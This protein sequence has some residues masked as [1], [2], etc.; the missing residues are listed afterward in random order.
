MSIL[1]TRVSR[2][3]DPRLLTE[4]GTLHGR[5][6]RPCARGRRA[7]HVRAVD[8]GARAGR[9]GR[10]RRGAQRCPGVVDVV[11]GADVDLAPAARR[12]ATARWPGRSWPS[13][14]S[15]SSASRWP[16]CSPRPPSRAPTP[17]SWWS[18]TTSRCP[19]VVD[20]A[21]ALDGEV[22]AL[23]R[24]G[25]QPRRRVRRTRPA[26]RS[27][28]RR[29]ARSWSASASS[30]SGWPPARS[31]GGRPRRRWVDGRL[32]ALVLDA[33]RPRP[34]AT[35]WRRRYGLDEPTQVRVIAPDVGGG[36]GA[37]IGG[38][39]EDLAARLAGPA[40]RP[41]GALDRDPHREHDRPWSTAGPRSRT[42]T[43]GGR[44]DGTHRG[45]PPRHRP[46]RR[47]LPAIGARSCPCLTRMMAAGTYAI[48]AVDLAR[49]GSVVTNTTPVGSPTAAPAGPR[50]RPPSS[51]R[52]TCS[53][54]RSGLDPAEVRR[55]NLVPAFDEAAHHADR[56]H[57]R[58]RR[59][60][61]ALDRALAAAGLRRAAGRAGAGA[62]AAGDPARSASG[63]RCY[64]EV[65]ERAAR[66]Q[67]VRPGRGPPG[68]RRR[69]RRRVSSPRA[70]RPTARATPPRW[71]CSPP[72]QLGM[73]DRARRGRARRHRR[74]APA[75]RARSARA[76][77]SSAA[78]RCGRPPARWSSRARRA[79]RR[80]ARGRRRR[81]RA[82]PR[83]PAASTWSASPAVGRSWAEVARRRRRR[84]RRRSAA[85]ELRR[86]DFAATQPTFPFGAHVAVVE[87]DTE[88]G[89]VRLRAPRRL[90]RR[91][92]DRSTRCWPRAS[93]TAGWPRARPRRCTRRSR[94][95]ADGNPLTTNF[96]DYAI[97]SAAELPSFE[98]VDMET[99]TLGQP[100]RGQGHRR[101]GHDRLRRPAVQNAVCDAAR[102]PRRAPRRHALHARTGV[103]GD[104][105]AATSGRLTK[106]PSAGAQRRVPE[107]RAAG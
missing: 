105:R 14:G 29:A 10:R 54:P 40:L 7:R 63:C 58:L 76:R 4:G 88:T 87:V 42:S 104:P 91:R 65:T 21:A 47:R 86:G 23:P 38:H 97:V 71:P 17:P 98:L 84:E 36:F 52:S 35:R 77:C 33:E 60:P 50:P 67:R 61:A 27:A 25:H 8:R 53:R 6:P 95:D 32:V 31:R 20:P 64:V 24:R 1:G 19:P 92:P 78:R 39:P 101:V 41:A 13:T 81:R 70:R 85:P 100:A 68:R 107:R 102:P 9:G 28:A 80:P 96:A 75:A 30:T 79:R 15:A 82:R 43:I 69:C 103:A 18:S 34:A 62:G 26:G 83:S 5:P 44:R 57:L 72:T 59:L 66:R 106:A 73:P 94:Y 51:G 12:W 22:A 48:P 46:G 56:R 99:P 3:E 11:T 93:A 89:E 55:R 45:L 16:S 74:R 49:P 2:I 37:K 90:R